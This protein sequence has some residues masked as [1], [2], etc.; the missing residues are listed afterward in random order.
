[1]ISSP[2]KMDYDHEISSP[3]LKLTIG[4]N[5]VKKPLVSPLP[6]LFDIPFDGIV[7]VHVKNDLEN[8]S[9]R[10]NIPY[11]MG[12]RGCEIREDH[13]RAGRGLAV[14]SSGRGLISSSL[15]NSSAGVVIDITPSIPTSKGGYIYSKNG[16]NIWNASGLLTGKRGAVP[17]R[18]L[19]MNS[20]LELKNHIQL[21]KE[22][23]SNNIP[24]LVRMWA[25]HVNDDLRLALKAGAD[26]IILIVERSL[27]DNNMG[28]GTQP[29]LGVFPSIRKNKDIHEKYSHIP[30]GVQL[31]IEGGSDITKYL[32]LGADYVVTWPHRGCGLCERCKG[33]V[34]CSSISSLFPRDPAIALLDQGEEMENNID[35]WEEDIIRDL[36]ALSL[37]GI[38]KLDH[39][40]LYAG[41]YSTAAISG[42]KLA[43]FGK[44]LPLWLH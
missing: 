7:D 26:S 9:K 20:V 25:G 44:T 11:I 4:E 5:R 38:D 31:K 24:V 32:A 42:L 12:A 2:C 13:Q 16:E 18:H 10:R 19:D 34:Q 8:I 29:V 36:V 23:T 6:L 37:S 39:K 27:L 33:G 28:Y 3:S 30:I 14:W 21:I 22:V 40:M 1:M 41:D 17:Y 35:E 43:G 15:L